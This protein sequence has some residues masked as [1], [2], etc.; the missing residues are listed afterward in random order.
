MWYLS[1]CLERKEQ[2][3]AAGWGLD[4][5]GRLLFSWAESLMEP[6]IRGFSEAEENSVRLAAQ[7]GVHVC[8]CVRVVYLCAVCVSY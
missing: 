7:G 1:F 8:V 4:P 2:E 3:E 6:D 5:Q